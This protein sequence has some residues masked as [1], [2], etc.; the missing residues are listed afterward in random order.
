MVTADCRGRQRYS[1]YPL[2]LI[3]LVY[4][5]HILDF[6]IHQDISPLEVHSSISSSLLLKRLFSYPFCRYTQCYQYDPHSNLRHLFLVFQLASLT[7]SSSSGT[8]IGNSKRIS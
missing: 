8:S 4:Y 3:K 1:D 5:Y 2:Y 6:I 7:Y